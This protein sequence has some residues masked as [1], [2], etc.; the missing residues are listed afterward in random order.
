MYTTSLPL[1]EPCGCL[2]IAASDR[3]CIT[4]RSQIIARLSRPFFFGILKPFFLPT[5]LIVS[6]RFARSSN[7]AAGSCAVTQHSAARNA[8]LTRCSRF[9]AFGF[10]P[11][12]TSAFAASLSHSVLWA[13]NLL[14][15]FINLNCIA[16]HIV[17]HCTPFL[18]WVFPCTGP[19][20]ALA[21]TEIQQPVP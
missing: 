3:W 11:P 7:G 16:R 4:R 18:S 10:G 19:M 5:L 17:W 13:F 8:G 14:A 2:S 21:V 6:A 1:L 9:A 12:I 20:L 15:G